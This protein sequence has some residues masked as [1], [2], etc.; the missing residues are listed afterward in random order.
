MSSPKKRRFGCLLIP[1]ALIILY[2][3]A[4]FL[5]RGPRPA[6]PQFIAHR[7]GDV[8]TPENTL[9]A[10]QN[11]I[12]LGANYIEFDVQMSVDGHLI[13]IH[14]DTVDRTTN[15]TGLVSEMTLDQI[16]ALDA[17]DGERV[18]TF[19]EVIQL[20][21]D[22]QVEILPEAKSPALYP[23]MPAKMVALVE[24]MDYLDHT[25]FQS[26]VLTAL[27]EMRVAN[28]DVATC[29]LFG[30][31]KFDLSEPSSADYVCPM[32]EMV[33]LNPWMVRAAHQRGQEVYIW[34]GVIE[35]PLTMRLMFAFGADGVMVDNPLAL[36]KIM[37]R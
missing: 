2:Y 34:F 16:R 36:K 6:D 8:T 5:L 27:D 26:F 17:G 28:V 18:P 31:W 19:E 7:G 33:L 30:L 21:K 24:E 13:V 23:G 35:H 37:N 4:Y 9:A 25:V 3:G 20:A 14:D 12:D 10:F 32:A 15:G 29:R 1:L 11:A 22:N